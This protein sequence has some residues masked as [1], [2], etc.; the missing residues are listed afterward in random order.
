M[1]NE[2]EVMGKGNVLSDD[3]LN[4][5]VGGISED[6]KAMIAFA[7]TV[8]TSIG[9]GV[10]IGVSLGRKGCVGLSRKGMKKLANK[11]WEIKKPDKEF[12]K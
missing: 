4:D 6:A 12:K 10:S 5:I 7:T 11:G 9:V 8:L 3:D 2:I 1:T